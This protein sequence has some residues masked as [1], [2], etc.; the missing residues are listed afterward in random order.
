MTKPWTRVSEAARLRTAA[1]AHRMAVL[2]GEAAGY[3]DALNAERATEFEAKAAA[4][5]VPDV[6]VSFAPTGEVVPRQKLHSDVRTV[7]TPGVAAIEAS[8]HRTTLLDQ[9]GEGVLAGGVDLAEG[10]TDS[11]QKMLAHQLALM[12]N[13][14]FELMEESGKQRDPIEKVRLAN[15]SSRLMTT[16]QQGLLTQQ[17]LKTGGDQRVTVTHVHVE[18]GAQAVIGNVTTGGGR[19]SCGKKDEIPC[20]TE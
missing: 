6:P 20:T 13:K 4:L 1:A 16:F 12:H 18:Q 10:A 2:E 9:A 8:E 11:R 15:A 17:R 14:A 5:L 7:R 19:G 3:P